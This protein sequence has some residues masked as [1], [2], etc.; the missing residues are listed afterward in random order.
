MCANKCLDCEAVSLYYIYSKLNPNE[1]NTKMGIKL[2]KHIGEHLKTEVVS[3]LLS[4]A[5]WV[6]LTRDEATLIL[7]KLLHDLDCTDG[8]DNIDGE[9]DTD[10]SVI[11]KLVDEGFKVPENWK[12]FFDKRD[13][14]ITAP[15]EEE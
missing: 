9:Y 8:L 4:G 10:W 2:T 5:E 1:R 3:S 15:K 11:N 6:E 14:M 12:P 13:G 7:D